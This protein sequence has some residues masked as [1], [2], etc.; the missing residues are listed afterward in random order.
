MADNNVEDV[1]QKVKDL[2]VKSKAKKVKPSTEALEVI[3][4]IRLYIPSGALTYRNLSSLIHS[5]S[6]FNIVL[7]C[8]TD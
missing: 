5:Q 2:S 1:A 8:L 3:M 6:T 7:I 4:T